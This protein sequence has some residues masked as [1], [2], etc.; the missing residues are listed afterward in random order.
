[1]F[2]G[3]VPTSR[4]ADDDSVGRTFMLYLLVLTSFI[5]LFWQAM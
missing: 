4:Y 1:M 5:F 2:L 3:R